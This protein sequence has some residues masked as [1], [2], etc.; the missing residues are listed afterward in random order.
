MPESKGRYTAGSLNN[1][2]TA[3]PQLF[4]FVIASSE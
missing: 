2:A 3:L 1:Y 4:L